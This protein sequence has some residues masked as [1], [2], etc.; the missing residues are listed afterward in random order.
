VGTAVC[1]GRAASWA[2]CKEEREKGVPLLSRKMGTIGECMALN[3]TQR[4]VLK[5]IQDKKA[6]TKQKSYGI[7]RI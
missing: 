2:S 5:E 3:E 4:A 6:E 1:L 7:F